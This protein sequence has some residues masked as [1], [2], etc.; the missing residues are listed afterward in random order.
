YLTLERYNEL[1]RS[2]LLPRHFRVS[3]DDLRSELP[4]LV[5]EHAWI[6]RGDEAWSTSSLE[7]DRAPRDRDEALLVRIVGRGPDW[8][9]HARIVVVIRVRDDTG[10]TYLL[11]SEETDVQNVF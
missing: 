2:N 3:M 4:G 10:K 9:V 7:P 8:P 6:L 11:R 1:H 5:A